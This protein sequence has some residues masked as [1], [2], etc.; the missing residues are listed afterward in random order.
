[1]N[2]NIED[3]PDWLKCNIYV[4]TGHRPP[5]NSVKECFKSMF[6]IHSQTGNIW[7]HFIGFLVFIIITILFYA[8]PSFQEMHKNLN[9]EEE[10]IFLI[11]FIG[12]NACL[13]FSW[14]YHTLQCHSEGVSKFFEKLDYLGILLNIAGCF[15]PL[16]YYC[17]SIVAFSFYCQYTMK[18]IYLTSSSILW[19]SAVIIVFKKKFGALEYKLTRAAVFVGLGCFCFLPVIHEIVIIGWDS[20]YQKFGFSLFTVAFLN[21]SGAFL[22][23]AKI[24]ERCF[25]G[26]LDIWFKS[27]Q[28]MHVLVF[29]A[30]IIHCQVIVNIFVFRTK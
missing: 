20:A 27:H 9:F 30:S 28:I 10:I 23:G 6:R 11:F 4:T 8:E 15:F 16:I 19:L 29:A 3:L 12:V 22:Y 25:P 26:K 2:V 7:T 1:M 17:P 21:L 24:P 18:M 14:L 5:M 13:C